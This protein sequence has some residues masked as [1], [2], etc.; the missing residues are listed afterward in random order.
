MVRENNES[1][2]RK[3]EELRALFSGRLEIV[4]AGL[5]AASNQAAP[6][7]GQGAEAPAP[8]AQLEGVKL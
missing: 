3:I 5:Q 4:E 7:A 1:L 6:G 2:E 8:V